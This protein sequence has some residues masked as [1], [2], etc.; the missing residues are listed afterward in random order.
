MF[1]FLIAG[2]QGA[3]DYFSPWQQ[4]LPFSF[5][6]WRFNNGRALF[7]CLFGNKYLKRS[8]NVYYLV[9]A[10]YDARNFVKFLHLYVL[11]S[12]L[13]GLEKVTYPGH[14]TSKLW[15]KD[16]NPGQLDAQFHVVSDHSR[17]LCDITTPR[18]QAGTLDPFLFWE[19]GLKYGAIANDLPWRFS[20]LSAENFLLQPFFTGL[21]SLVVLWIIKEEI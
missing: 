18:H 9:S 11:L 5:Q 21:L 2:N 14:S 4:E 6:V 1:S 19:T 3:E 7:F 15:K 17:R 12:P 8:K 10:Y 20:S 13:W 16:S